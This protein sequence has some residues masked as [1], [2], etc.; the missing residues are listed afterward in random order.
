MG[1]GREE[2]WEE[3]C[4]LRGLVGLMLPVLNGYHIISFH[5]L[6]PH[7]SPRR[8]DFE[9]RQMDLG[10]ALRGLVGILPRDAH[11]VIYRD[12]I[13]NISSSNMMHHKDRVCAT[14]ALLPSM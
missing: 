1:R 13:G 9:R 12:S 3:Q 10:P 4:A 14:V 8:L 2:Q 11:S 6:S 7:L 5:F